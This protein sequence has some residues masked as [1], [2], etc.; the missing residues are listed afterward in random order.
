MISLAKLQPGQFRAL[1]GRGVKKPIKPQVTQELDYNKKMA[2][3]ELEKESEI[4]EMRADT[5]AAKQKIQAGQALALR[6]LD[7]LAPKRSASTAAVAPQAKRPISLSRI[8]RPTEGKGPRHVE[9]PGVAPANPTGT[10]IGSTLMGQ[11]ELGAMS[12]A[13]TFSFATTLGTM[14]AS[15][16][17]GNVQGVAKSAHKGSKTVRANEQFADENMAGLQGPSAPPN[18]TSVGQS[19]G[20]EGPGFGGHGASAAAVGAGGVGGPTGA[21]GP[22]FGGP[23]VSGGAPPAPGGGPG[24]K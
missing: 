20:A 5:E 18:S 24:G 4:E 7:A 1:T 21:E 12:D 13:E 3:L 2:E 15:A 9:A 23:G 17:T 14:L 22:G 16:F 19:T 10:G 11:Q 6:E 8:A